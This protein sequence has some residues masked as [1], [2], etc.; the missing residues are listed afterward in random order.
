MTAPENLVSKD[1]L[2]QIE[3]TLER[4]RSA[5]YA[6]VPVSYDA[7]VKRI[8]RCMD[9]IIENQGAIIDAVNAD[10]GNRSR[11]VTLMMDLFTSVNAAKHVKKHLKKWMK[12]EKRKSPF[13]LGLFGARAEIQY[14]PKGVIG[15]MA[16]WN[17]PVSMVFS[18]LVEA[19][20]AGNRAMI[21]P[22]EFTPATSALLEELFPKYFD[23]TEAVIVN[24]GP[25]VGAAFSSLNFD[26]IIFTGATSI[27]RHVMRAAAENLTPVTLEL[28]GKSPVVVGRE[29]DLQ[30]CGEK[31]FAGKLMNAGQVCVSPDYCFVPEELLEDFIAKGQEVVA[32]LYPTIADNP[33]YV[34]MI[35]ERHFE[36]VTSYINDAKERGARVIEINP[37][38]EDLANQTH[39]KIALTLVVNPDD[40]Y[41]SMQNEI[42]GPILNIKTYRNLDDVISD[43]NKR[44]RPLAFYYFGTNK[45]EAQWVLDRTIAGGVSVNDIAMHV[46]CDDMPF[47][48]VGDSGIGSY[49]GIEGFKTFSHAKSVFKQGKLNLGKLAGTLP[50]YTDKVDKMMAGQIKK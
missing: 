31:L 40:D 2:T 27:G 32:G 43:I 50:P 12:P 33:D 14:Q 19:F 8:D 3:T 47:G 20:G 44:A 23:E 11:H 10:F 13:P 15:I 49:H 22:S 4:Q 48:G 34:S 30:D 1:T 18:P 17:V 25:E 37:A 9:L 35:N 38:N 36:R 41:L 24:G 29:L 21:K 42:F 16:P 26:H 5:F 45:E 39:N 7:R 28:G 6:E 46:A